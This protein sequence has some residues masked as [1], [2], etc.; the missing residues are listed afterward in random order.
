MPL[1]LKGVCRRTSSSAED[2]FMRQRVP[3]RAGGKA[4]HKKA[5]TQERIGFS[6]EGRT[7]IDQLLLG[8]LLGEFA[9]GFQLYFFTNGSAAR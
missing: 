1:A 6:M 2:V 7:W 5:D 9:S 8:S 3:F 4:G